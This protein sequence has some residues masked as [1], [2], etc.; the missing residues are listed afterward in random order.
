MA[1]NIVICAD[2]TGNA[3]AKRIS[4]V[5]R[6]VKLLALG[7]LDK[8]LVFYDQGIGTHPDLRRAIDS[9]QK[10]KNPLRPALAVLDEPCRPDWMP[11]RIAILL[12]KVFGCGL[13]DNVLQMYRAVS[14]HWNPGD[15]VF[16]FGFSR[17]AFTVR[18]LAGL[19]Y[20]CGLL[21]KEI[22]QGAIK[23]PAF[24]TAFELYSPHDR[25]KTSIGQF[26]NK[27]GRKDV[28]EVNFLGIWD[29]VKAYGG[30][31]PVSLP[32]LRHNPRVLVVRHALA[33]AERRAWFVP[34]SWG[35]I[36]GEDLQCLKVEPDDGY[37]KQKVQ[38]VWFCGCHCDVGGGDCEAAT[39]AIPL[40]WMLREADEQGLLLDG[41]AKQICSG[42]LAAAKTK[43]HES[44]GFGHWLADCVPHQ[45]LD[46]SCSPPA[47]RW[48]AGPTGNRSAANFRRGGKVL[49]HHSAKSECQI[50]NVENVELV[51]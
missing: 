41:D 40:A 46:N 25:D 4:N 2:G 20:R 49:V 29:T 14:Q 1:K 26:I 15:K 31:V 9:F 13:K 51:N 33:L 36:D 34:T 7:N 5:S 10:S 43:T 3:F 48:K 19:I 38:E 6:L 45:E 12:G 35:G 17:G 18:V 30:I 21:R 11:E 8:Q 44:R 47:R 16:L 42:L 24:Q 22:A 50:E 28:C 37:S 32:H 23:S 39:A 27:F